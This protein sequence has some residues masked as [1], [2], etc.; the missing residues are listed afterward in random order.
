MG[1]L[2]LGSLAIYV[3][4]IE[5]VVGSGR[6]W[7]TFGLSGSLILGVVVIAGVRWWLRRRRDSVE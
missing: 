1:G 3:K 7:L 2:S 6:E 4:I 5:M